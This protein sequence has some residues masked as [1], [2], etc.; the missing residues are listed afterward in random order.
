MIY[1]GTRGHV[2]A[3]DPATGEERWRTKLSTGFFNAAYAQ[4]VMVLVRDGIVI[5]GCNGHMWGLDAER[6]DI[7]WHN[8]LNGLGHD[9]ISMAA[10]G[11]AIQYVHKHT[12]S[13]SNS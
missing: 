1:G 4:D 13:N 7:L 6:G 11:V 10:E 8:G 3:I 2:F 12:R 5:A 9:A